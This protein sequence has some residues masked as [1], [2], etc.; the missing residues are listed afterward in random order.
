MPS[1]HCDKVNQCK[2]S[3]WC[4]I[5]YRPVNKNCFDQLTNADR[6]RAMSDEELA[7]TE[8]LCPRWASKEPWTC[9]KKYAKRT[10]GKQGYDCVAC[11]LDWLKSPVEVDNG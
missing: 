11:V 3:W 6:I 7:A 1:N 8:M 10:D 2:N 9:P 4:A 5:D